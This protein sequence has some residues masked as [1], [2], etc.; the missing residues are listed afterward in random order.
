MVLNKE[1]IAALDKSI[2]KWRSIRDGYYRYGCPLCDASRGETCNSCIYCE[3]NFGPGCG[4]PRSPYLVYL[5]ESC[6]ANTEKMLQS[7]IDTKE[8]ALRDWYK[9]EILKGRY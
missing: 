2:E 5:L 6:D 8:A 3:T 4:R 7:L 1:Q 9:L